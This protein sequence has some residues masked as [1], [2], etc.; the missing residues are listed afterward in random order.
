MRLNV[1][2]WCKWNYFGYLLGSAWSVLVLG[3]TASGVWE[4]ELGDCLIC[5]NEAVRRAISLRRHRGISCSLVLER[6]HVSLF[7]LFL[8]D[9]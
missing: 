8:D 3:S 7:S 2:M 6:Q 1:V 9:V 5:G 4:K